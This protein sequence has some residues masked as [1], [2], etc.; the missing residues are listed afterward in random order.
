MGFAKV[1]S[2]SLSLTLVWPPGAIA[3]SRRVAI[4]MDDLPYAA[5]DSRALSPSDATTAAEVNRSLVA[6]LRKHQV[7][8]T[9]FVI[10]Q[11]VDQLG[12]A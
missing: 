11:R 5:G 3:Q 2:V 12:V 10:Q 6:A 4:T 9:G 8:A 7:P 1:V